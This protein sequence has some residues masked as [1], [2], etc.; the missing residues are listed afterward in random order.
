MSDAKLSTFSFRHFRII[1]SSFNFSSTPDKD[2]SITILPKGEYSKNTK[3]YT[4][5]LNVKVNDKMLNLEVINIVCESQFVFDEEFTDEIPPYFTL[6]APAISFPYIRSYVAAL[7]ALSG[8]GTLNLPIL[9]LV[10]LVERLKS[11]FT[12]VD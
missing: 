2:M 7:S 1:R 6:N 10:D 8:L 9:N 4:L 3:L 12:V 11:N 5:T